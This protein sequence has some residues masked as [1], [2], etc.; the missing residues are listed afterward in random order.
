MRSI[1]TAGS[2]LLSLFLAAPVF[3]QAAK[4]LPDKPVAEA[5]HSADPLGRETPQGAVLGFIRAAE[6]ENYERAAQYLDSR[7]SPRAAPE[8]AR[9]LK[10]VMDRRL[11]TTDIDRLSPQPEGWLDENLPPNLEQV[12]EVKGEGE[13][14]AI[15][16]ERVERPGQGPVWLVS[17]RTLSHVP[18][19]HRELE[20][21]WIERLMPQPWREFRILTLPL[22]Q[23]VVFLLAIP[24][25]LVLA[26][27]LHRLLLKG[28]RPLLHRLTGARADTQFTKV[29][30][31]LRLLTGA[32]ALGSWAFLTALPLLTRVFWTRVAAAMAIAGAAW[33]LFRLADTIAELAETRLR[34]VNRIGR[35]AVLHL[36]KQLA[37]A[38]VVLMGA[39]AILYLAGLDLTAALAGLGIGGIALAFAAQKTLENLFGG[40]MIIS[41]EPVR[42]RDFCRIGDVVGVVEEIG[43]RSTRVGRSTGPG[44]HP[45]GQTAVV[46]VENFGV[47]DKVWFRPTIGLRYETSAEQ[48]RYVLTEVRQMLYGHPMVETHSSCVRLVRFGASSLDLEMFAYVLTSDYPTFLEVQEDLLLRIMD[49]IEASG[50]AI[51]FP[52]STTYLARDGG[53]DKEK[54]QAA[55]ETVKRWRAVGDLPFPNCRL[56]RIA[57]IE[58]RLDYPESDSAQARR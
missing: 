42:V 46:N 23:W 54:A 27:G 2:L 8:L 15:L 29:A 11:R 49:I 45:D 57:E 24:V 53:L 38:T 14:V 28:L 3:G 44:E 20:L 31:P 21:S 43:L 52:S 26:W 17:A 30:A 56:E 50:T 35:L 4:Q 10:A 34:Y 1:L 16:L 37:K 51:G 55:I 22:W 48:L 33:L 5:P 58:N 18:I 19:L 9:Q 40:I 7:A 13:P 25:I 32:V 39:L 12:G 6:S 36:V 47:R 41:D